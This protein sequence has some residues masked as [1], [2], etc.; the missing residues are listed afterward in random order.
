MSINYQIQELPDALE[1]ERRTYPRPLTYNQFGH[2]K[3][4]S[5][6]AMESGVQQGVVEAV[7]TGLPDAI[8]NILL[9]GHTV[10]INGLGTFSL[11]LAFKNG[12]DDFLR[13]DL[14]KLSLTTSS[15]DDNLADSRPHV[16]INRLNFKPDPN[17]LQTLRTEADLIKVEKDTIPI[18]CTTDKLEAHTQLAMQHLAI[19]PVLFLQDFA[20]LIHASTSTASRQLHRICSLPDSPITPIGTG[21][22]TVWVKKK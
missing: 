22:R 5:R 3:M 1:G 16:T 9:E 8:K 21:N 18:S 10:K 2:K 15:D 11:S 19:H 6:I 7:L 13:Q 14:G 17:L 4:A 20:N 12:N